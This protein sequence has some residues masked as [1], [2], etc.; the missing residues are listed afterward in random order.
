[1]RILSNPIKN[2]S[3][4]IAGES[5]ASGLGALIAL[6]NDKKYNLL[7]ANLNILIIN[8]EGDTDK[9]N[10]NKIMKG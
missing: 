7:N 4:I 1:M 5:G 3:I 2:D 9:D 8:T 10:Y 6:K